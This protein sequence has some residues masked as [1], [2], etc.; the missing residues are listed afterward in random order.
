MRLRV[1]RVGQRVQGSGFGVEGLGYR[2]WD[3][4]F[5]DEGVSSRVERFRGV[6]LVQNLRFRLGVQVL[7]LRV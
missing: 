1:E 5:G 2:V 3:L 7:G 4:V 6:L